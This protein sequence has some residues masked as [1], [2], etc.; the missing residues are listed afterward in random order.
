MGNSLGKHKYTK[1]YSFD[2]INAMSTKKLRKVMC[3]I[4]EDH[5]YDVDRTQLIKMYNNL[6]G[7]NTSE[8]QDY[9]LSS[10]S[11]NNSQQSCATSPI[12]I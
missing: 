4:Y 11:S 12:M 7:C 2:D 9:K 6:T 1:K 3:G 8:T 5:I 10:I